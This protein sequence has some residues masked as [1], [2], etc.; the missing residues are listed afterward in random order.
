MNSIRAGALVCAVAMSVVAVVATDGAEWNQDY[1]KALEAAKKNSKPLLV[2]FEEPSESLS[3]A[4]SPAEITS[5]SLLNP[6]ELCRVDV[7]TP[8]GKKVAKSFGASRFPYTVITDK[9]ARNIICRKAGNCTR[10]DWTSMLMTYR[11][12]RKPVTYIES[13]L[14]PPT[15][16]F[17]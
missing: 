2:V 13:A 16:C 17:T 10:L 3:D 11:D 1:G 9:Q 14:A 6:Y 8:M 15:V 5:G 7:T 4:I 12:G